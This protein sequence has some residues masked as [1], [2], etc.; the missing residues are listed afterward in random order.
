MSCLTLVERKYIVEHVLVRLRGRVYVF[1]CMC[2]SV[3]VSMYACA[4]VCSQ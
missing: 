2:A 1:V 4:R 3:R